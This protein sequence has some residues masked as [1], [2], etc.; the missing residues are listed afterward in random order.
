MKVTSLI[1]SALQAARPGCDRSLHPIARSGKDQA[2][3]APC[4]PMLSTSLIL[5]IQHIEIKRF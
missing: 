2:A 3:G 1:T 5:R 4:Q